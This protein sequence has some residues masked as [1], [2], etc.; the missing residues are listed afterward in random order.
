MG[1]PKALPKIPFHYLEG[2]LVFGEEERVYAY[3]ELPMYSYSFVGEEQAYQFQ[4]AIMRLIRQ[5]HSPHV[6]FFFCTD[7]ERIEKAIVSSK[8]LVRSKG[9]LKQMAYQHLESVQEILEEMH[10]NYIK[11]VRCYLGFE[12]VL[13]KNDQAEKSWLKECR[14][15]A[16]DFF[17]RSN[18][19]LF[20]GF[21]T[22]PNE[23][24]HRYQRLE[25][26]LYNRIGK[27]FRLRKTTPEDMVFLVEHL[28]GKKE[29]SLEEVVVRPTSFKEENTTYAYQYDV[30]NLASA[31]ITE[32]KNYLILDQG[33]EEDYVSYL[34]L[35]RMTRDLSFPFQ[36]EIFYFLQSELDFPIDCSLDIEC[37]DNRSALTKV[38]GKKSDLSDI[39]ES[40]VSVG[41]DV[42]NNVREAYQSANELEQNLEDT[43]EDMYQ[44]SLVVRVTGQTHDE[45]LKRVSDVRSFFDGYHMY[46]E[47]PCNVQLF[48]HYECY[49]AGQRTIDDYRQ[50]VTVDFVGSL[51]FGATQY[52]GDGCGIPIGFNAETGAPVFIQ[53]WLA[54]QGIKGTITNALAKALIGSLGGG[55]S[56]TENLL[57]FWSVLFGASAFCIDPKSERL[58]WA[59]DLPY[60]APYLKIVN[61]TSEKENV[62]LLDP[63]QLM[64]KKRDQE[65]LA[66][67]V[68]TYITGVSIRDEDRFPLLQRA[69]KT[70]S[71]FEGA[72]GLLLVIQELYAQETEVAQRLAKHIESFKELSIAGLLFGDGTNQQGLNLDAKC[73]VA[74]VQDLTLPDSE[75]GTDDYNSS[76][77]LS[78]AIMMSLATY[79]LDFIKQNRKIYKAVG[80]DESW[81]WL[82][83]AQGKILGNKLV[84]E[85]RSRNA[86]IDF[87]TQNTDDLGDEKMKSKIG[88]KFIF[89]SND[90]E[91]IIKAL[92][93]CGI[94]VTEETIQRVK[95]LENGECLFCDIHGNVGILYVYYWFEDVFHAFDTRPPM[96]EESEEE[97]SV[98]RI[99]EIEGI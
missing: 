68:L 56:L 60:F 59:E 17:H 98:E 29:Q 80:L 93:F 99:E 19:R 12:L 72:K 14:I 73:N 43:R 4:Q 77:I 54:A 10:G 32:K 50:Y 30:L 48:L 70:V 86:G 65:S 2:N 22:I 35:S 36:S 78:V 27:Y 23:K 69:V 38:R 1:L 18:A 82:N 46:L 45:L 42:G 20:G 58:K 47:V 57:L 7:E 26:L 71:D 76:E 87:S 74:L 64:R 63:F 15:F 6:R 96:D 34:A 97:D 85:G 44:L 91:E 94:S 3:Y 75:T 16:K 21:E 25:S 52:L 83:V 62:G 8:K 95:N 37:L 67:D 24:I 13:E 88:L 89:R 28:E 9:K 40:G 51:G 41:K 33:M 90:R 79:A 84:R 11:K 39:Y 92:N 49:P 53:P 81:A 5:S 61:I 31:G 55:K 66:L